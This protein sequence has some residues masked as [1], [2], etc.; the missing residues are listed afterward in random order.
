MKTKKTKLRLPKEFA[1]KWLE[2]LRSGDYKQGIEELFHQ[3]YNDSSEIQESFC[4]LG[5]ACVRAGISKDVIESAGLI[6]EDYFLIE[7]LEDFIKQGLPKELTGFNYLTRVLTALNDGTSLE[8]LKK[9]GDFK[10]DKIDYNLNSESCF[11][12]TFPQIADFI[13]NNVEFYKEI[14]K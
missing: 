1:E 4:C 2:A 3:D 6:D 12:L 9:F 7:E 8:Y 14:K 10:F 13:E 11:S 5:V